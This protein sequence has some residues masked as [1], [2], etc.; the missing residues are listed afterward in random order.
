MGIFDKAKGTVTESAG[1]VEETYGDVTDSLEHQLKGQAK[2]VCGKGMRVASQACDTV[3]QQIEGNPLAS[4][5]I[6]A[7]VGVVLGYLLGRK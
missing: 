2:Q 7:G 3:K 6:V 4:V 5:A 1:H